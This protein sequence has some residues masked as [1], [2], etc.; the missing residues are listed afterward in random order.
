[1]DSLTTTMDQSIRADVGRA[2]A[3]GT[4]CI[5]DFKTIGTF[6][7]ADKFQR[8]RILGF[9]ITLLSGAEGSKDTKHRNFRG[10]DNGSV[11]KFA[12]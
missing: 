2:F 5:R 4:V 1:M 12:I 3:A 8:L 7:N 11:A 10:A 6:G 9:C